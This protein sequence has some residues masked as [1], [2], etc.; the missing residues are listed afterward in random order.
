MAV[1]SKIEAQ[2]RG[3]QCDRCA[4]AHIKNGG[5]VGSE[6]RG[7]D[8]II[9]GEAPGGEEIK[10]GQPFVG[11]SGQELV[12]G[13]LASGLQRS[14]VSIANA[15]CCR[16]INN[17]M[18][19]VRVELKKL[20]AQREADGLDPLL[21]PIAACRPRL[22]ADIDGH[23][24][25][26]TLGGTALEGVIGTR[27][28]ILNVRGAPLGENAEHPNW[29]IFPTLHPAF[30]LRQMRWRHVLH[31]D[32]TRAFRY[33]RNEKT[34]VDPK[35]YYR[36]T[37]KQIKQ[38]LAQDVSFFSC[39]LETDA[40]EPTLAKIR[41]IGI[42]TTTHCIIVPLLSIDGQTKFYNSAKQAAIEQTM[43]EFFTAPIRKV[44]HNFGSYDKLVIGAALGVETK[45][46]TDTILLHR[47]VE[48]EMPHN[49]GYVGSV[50]TDIDKS[51]KSEH[52]ATAAKTDQELW[53]YCGLDTVVTARI[54]KPLLELV[55]KR[56]QERVC[57]IDHKL[58]E[59][60]VGMHRNGM[61]VDLKKRDIWDQ[62]LLKDTVMYRKQCR[63]LIDN[64]NFNPASVN[65]IKDL[66]FGKWKMPIV[67]ETESGEPSTGDDVIRTLMLEPGL[68]RKQKQFLHS[69]RMFRRRAKL[70]G[71]YIVKL[72]S[73]DEI[74]IQDD[75]ALDE[76]DDP[77]E[78]DF[79]EKDRKKQGIIYPDGRVRSSWN[80][81]GTNTGRFS[82]SGPNLQNMPRKLREIFIPGD[83]NVFVY[84]DMD[85]L[86]LRLI[87]AFAG[88]QRYLRVFEEG[89]DPHSLSTQMVLGKAC[90]TMCEALVKKY[91]SLKAARKKDPDWAR[92][93]DFGK[94]FTYAAGY[95]A[96]I[97]TIH[98]VLRSAE[99]DSERLI[100][101]DLTIEKTQ[102][103][104]NNWIGQNPEIE[105]WW[106]SEVD[107][108]R[109]KGFSVD[110]YHGRRCDFADGE[111]ENQ[112]INY[113]CQSTGAAIV[114]EGTL[115]F[116]E[117]IYFERFGKG[118]GL[119]Q[120]G[121][122]ALLPEVPR[123][124]GEQ[125]AAFL[126]KCLTRKVPGLP[127]TFTAAAKVGD[128]WGAF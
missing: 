20:N 31:K 35:V 51:W 110:A 37:W 40:I 103:S 125:V 121:H 75:F 65:Q 42:S 82:S 33:F 67:E 105:Q 1:Y 50:Y 55:K 79:R 62:R 22:H 14:D 56:K 87:A 45:P 102:V 3:A 72:K 84:A 76:M 109:K 99:D 19:R 18:D 26:L 112:I 81:H 89:G 39:D 83:G 78:R 100:Y 25:V 127:V 113:R 30:V 116:V 29:Q 114:N 128:H 61:R 64:D 94:R 124:Y 96:K 69:L 90:E 66:L 34:W 80:V 108:Y 101:A 91:G 73:R 11:A 54:A 106:A 77:D 49:L 27:H 28:S 12:K 4:F 115:Q 93:C 122:D 10:A 17:K 123:K 118:T 43:R 120:Q 6:I 48:S 47:S 58:Q 15:I 88:A 97:D 70:R 23:E 63:E 53:T 98:E 57:A 85:Q 117:K 95:K 68:D 71:T 32:I 8:T 16:P 52:T 21:H 41:C 119:V 38:F 59:V 107:A 104:Y 92:V 74:Y 111:N 2:K 9:V 7:G 86:E 24:H 46:I 36:P 60:C 5:F 13:L 44:G 126:Q